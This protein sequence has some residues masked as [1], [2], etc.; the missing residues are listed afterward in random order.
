MTGHLENMILIQMTAYPD[1]WSDADRREM[2]EKHLGF[3]TV[4]LCSGC[5]AELG[6]DHFC[7]SCEEVMPTYEWERAA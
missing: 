4:D 5:D 7:K 1:C 6:P 3:D 2:A